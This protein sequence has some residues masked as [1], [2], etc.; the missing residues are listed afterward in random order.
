[1]DTDFENKIKLIDEIGTD[2]AKFIVKVCRVYM[3]HNENLKKQK[4]K[5]TIN[6]MKNREYEP[7][8][9]EIIL[10]D[11]VN[12]EKEIYKLKDS[13]EKVIKII[14][15]LDNIYANPYFN[16]KMRRKL[17]MIVNTIS[18]IK[19]SE[20]KKKNFCSKLILTK[21]KN[22][23][24]T[25]DKNEK[26]DIIDLI[27]WLDKIKKELKD[28]EFK[29]IFLADDLLEENLFKEEQ[30]KKAIDVINIT[31]TKQRYKRI[32]EEVYK[33]LNE[34]FISNKYC[35]FKNNQCVAQRNHEFI[36]YIRKNGCCFTT[37]RTC[38]NLKDGKCNIECLPC[39]LYSCPYL[40]KRGI[41]Y[42]ASEI[43]LFKAF[44]TKKQRKILVFDFYKPKEKILKKVLKS[45]EE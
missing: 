42:Y 10:N 31:D 7:C 43:I 44:L 3:Q 15:N 2:D 12:Q 14:I 6:L 19:L 38:P 41:T 36:P 16:T 4:E 33:Y 37:I 25:E 29:F 22:I 34:D 45:M 17:K 24:N 27:Q 13:N 1:M 20:M 21:V 28:I 23:E 5:S 39:R 26:I 30:I 18:T 8:K 35:D 11:L 32:Y 40:S 9:N